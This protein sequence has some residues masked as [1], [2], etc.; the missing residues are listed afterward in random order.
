METVAGCCDLT[1]DVF[2]APGWVLFS[3]FFIFC[4]G[5]SNVDWLLI[6]LILNVQGLY[7]RRRLVIVLPSMGNMLEHYLLAISNVTSERARKVNEGTRRSLTS[8]PVSQKWNPEL[9]SEKS[10]AAKDP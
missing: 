1:A 9:K 7:E 2:M 10:S 6:K 3:F 8:L 4:G 5:A